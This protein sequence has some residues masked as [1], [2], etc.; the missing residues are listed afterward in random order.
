[1][2]HLSDLLLR[3]VRIGLLTPRGGKAYFRRIQKLCKPVLPWSRKQWKQEIKMYI[4][5]WKYAYSLPEIIIDEIC[6]QQ[7][8]LILKIYEFLKRYYRKLFPA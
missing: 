3:R 8:S 2:R 7:Q 4:D 6:E 1:V 5:Q